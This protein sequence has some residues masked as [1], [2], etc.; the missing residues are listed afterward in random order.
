[1][2]FDCQIS[3]IENMDLAQLMSMAQTNGHF[4]ELAE[5]VFKRKFAQKTIYFKHPLQRSRINLADVTIEDDCVEIFSF[6]MAVKFLEMFGRFITS[7]ALDFVRRH[8]N[9]YALISLYCS[10]TVTH[11][12]LI[13]V[14][15]YVSDHGH[16]EH[17][18]KPFEKVIRLSLAGA[19][20]ALDSVKFN[21][22]ELFPCIENL[23]IGNT[24]IRNISFADQK[25]PHLRALHVDV[26]PETFLHYSVDG[27][28]RKLI[29]NNR[30]I[31]H[32]QLER[33]SQDLLRFVASQLEH[34]AS[35]SLVE[36]NEHDTTL[37]DIIQLDSVK[38]FRWLNG[39]SSVPIN[40]QFRNLIELETD[41][42]PFYCLK[43][44]EFV[45]QSFTLEKLYLIGRYIEIEEMAKLI[46]VIRHLVEF[47][48][49][50][51]I[52]IDIGIV[53]QLV[54]HGEQLRKTHLKFIDT[55]GSGQWAFDEMMNNLKEML[56]EHWK[57]IK[58]Q[59]KLEIQLTR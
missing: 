18:T 31:E 22:N 57:T 26:K 29:Q 4:K 20:E 25:L 9:F 56:P 17:F 6:N 59:Q 51:E 10:E 23:L 52:D 27:M 50:V 42:G 14:P 45:G 16:F 54:K 58:N 38:Q 43:W 28:V 7:L 47:S 34:L 49:R 37:D 40:M 46:P 2:H 32:L 39:T 24:F 48:G 55:N 19:F 13:S 33:S 41:A 30:Q 12:T 35:L 15:H 21:F 36:H 53:V 5:N 1:M 3:V 11:L 44:I 8:D